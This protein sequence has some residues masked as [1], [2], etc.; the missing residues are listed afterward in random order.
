MFSAL[1]FKIYFIHSF[2]PWIL[3]SYINNKRSFVLQVLISNKNCKLRIKNYT[4]KINSITSNYK[5]LLGLLK[6]LRFSMLFEINKNGLMNITFDN[7]SFFQINL[8]KLSITDQKLI[9]LL[10]DAIT[11]GLTVIP[12]DN[13]SSYFLDN[14]CI[15]VNT[16]SSPPNSNL[17]NEIII[18]TYNKVNFLL[19]YYN[20]TIIETFYN[21][22]HEIS[23]LTDFQNKIVFDV[24]ASIG[25]TALYFSNKGAEVY[26]IEIDDRNF[27]ILS[28]H[29]KINPHLSKSIHPIHAA[30]SH[31]GEIDYY[32]DPEHIMDS[33][34]FG[35][36]FEGYFNK[37]DR[38][39]IKSY[40][41]DGLM[42][43][44]NLKTIDFLKI[45]CKGCEFTL[46]NKDLENVQNLKIEY[47]PIDPSHDISNLIKLIENSNFQLRLFQHEVNTR[48]SFKKGGNILA[49]KTYF[50]TSQKN[51]I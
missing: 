45:D 2:F 29:L 47:M 49:T 46:T 35:S 34:L 12:Q 30:L 3:S 42:K 43:L 24:G 32:S 39:K 41:I 27:I 15:F 11:Y 6:I 9:L 26:A 28:E 44:N 31:D 14:R 20:Y 23:T 36:R 18:E 17:D 4:L 10:D 37:S 21:N 48:K 40:S 5:I 16:Q 7:I 51:K 8:D 19:K 38:K 50:P 33:T 22:I 25:E 13:K 1:K